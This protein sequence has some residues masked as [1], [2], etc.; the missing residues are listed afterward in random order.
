MMNAVSD[1]LSRARDAFAAW[2][3]THGRGRLPESL[4]STALELPSASQCLLRGVVW[5]RSPPA[6]PL[7]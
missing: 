7:A 5:D 1:D 4:W 3:A 6:R 2:R